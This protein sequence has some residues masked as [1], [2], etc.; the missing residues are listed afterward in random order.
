MAD[1]PFA[2]RLRELRGETR[3]RVLAAGLG[4]SVPLISSWE[5]GKAVPPPER[6]EGYARF[7]ATPRSIDDD[8]HPRLL[9]ADEMDPDE[10]ESFRVLHTE[11]LRLRPAA[12]HP[13]RLPT[14]PPPEGMWH[15][16]DEAPITIVCA[17]LPADLRADAQY[18]SPDSPDYIE[19]YTYADLDA[20]VELYGHLVAANPGVPVNR[21]LAENLSSAD[22]TNHLVL[23]GGVD[24]NPMTRQVM[25][26]LDIPVSQERREDDPDT[27][28]F[29]VEQDG[30]V[31]V[32]HSTLDDASEPPRLLEDVAQFSRGPN[33]FNRLRTVTI[34]NGNYGRGTLG[35]VRALTDSRFR[36]RN[37]AYLEARF[38]PDE[39]YSLLSRVTIVQGTVVTPDWTLEGTVLHEWSKAA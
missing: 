15:F 4:V 12:R 20:L 19:L 5:S 14:L 37:R 30:R 24:W 11:L 8:G 38:G 31:A 34:C 33:P 10:L 22:L 16:A 17:A 13:D 23:L 18:T 26:E 35:A 9:P 21:K 2:R 36:D 6:L 3:Q 1:D 39:T 29:R 25:S 32:F 27:G 28:A 7:F